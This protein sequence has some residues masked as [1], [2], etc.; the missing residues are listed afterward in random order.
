MFLSNQ[1]DLVWHDQRLPVCCGSPYSVLS[2]SVHRRMTLKTVQLKSK[3][4]MVHIVIYC[5]R[6]SVFVP[7][8]FSF[9]KIFCL[10]WKCVDSQF[11]HNFIPEVNTSVNYKYQYD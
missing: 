1:Q 9:S 6:I 2:G 3:F 8:S 11:Y 10:F 4:G 5:D 7:R